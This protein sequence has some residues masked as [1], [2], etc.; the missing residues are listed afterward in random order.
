MARADPSSTSR[1]RE[2]SPP[3]PSWHRDYRES[4][5]MTNGTILFASG[6]LS[7][8]G[9]G[10]GGA[11]RKINYRAYYGAALSRPRRAASALR[12][13]LLLPSPSHWPALRRSRL[14][15][16]APSGNTGISTN[17]VRMEKEGNEQQ[18]GTSFLSSFTTKIERTTTTQ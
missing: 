12:V 13:N 3:S 1:G 10:S 14:W 11:R 2:A 5:S 8:S 4:A 9:L 18:R 6:R 7:A 16:Q 17:F 15:A